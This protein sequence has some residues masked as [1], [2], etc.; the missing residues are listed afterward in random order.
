MANHPKSRK[1]NRENGLTPIPRS[2]H[3]PATTDGGGSNDENDELEQMQVEHFLN[4]LARIALAAAAR[5]VDSQGG[6]LD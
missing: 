5:R 4:T 3:C 1:S 6:E 2:I